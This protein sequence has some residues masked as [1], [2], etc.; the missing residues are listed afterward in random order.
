MTYASLDDL[1]ARAGQREI[2][3]VADRDHDGVADAD[4]VAEALTHADNIV[5][6]YVATAYALPFSAVPDL[7]RTW[8][9]A[10]ARHKLHHQGP[11]DYV[12]A[13]YKD[14]IASLKDVQ[15]GKL[16]L[17]VET[18]EIPHTSA[19]TTMFADA[20]TPSACEILRGW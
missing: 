3:D 10:I 9:V 4:V 2:L 19:G 12:V 17:P 6:G 20:V 16:T 1:V 15:S 8:A 18:G 7:V 5:N 14:A 13:D 11:P